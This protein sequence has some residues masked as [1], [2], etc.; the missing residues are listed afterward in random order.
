M[1]R[2]ISLAIVLLTLILIPVLARAQSVSSLFSQLQ[3]LQSMAS[4]LQSQIN[5]LRT[6]TPTYYNTYYGVNN[7]TPLVNA[8]SIAC[9]IIEQN[10]E[11]GFVDY[12]TGG[13]ISELQKFLTAVGLYTG[14]ISGQ[15][16]SATLA[17]IQSFQNQYGVASFGN[18]GYGMV[19]PQTRAKIKAICSGSG[20]YG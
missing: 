20:S 10:L 5:S 12:K 8:G 15:Y 3:N 11:Y 9:P 1:Q 2:K 7:Y 19:G 18:T 6:T 17:A 14:T 16:N 13:P 4:V